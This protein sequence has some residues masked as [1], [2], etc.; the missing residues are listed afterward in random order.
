M[1]YAL[2]LTEFY[3]SEN[4]IEAEG[5]RN[6]LSAVKKCEIVGFSSVI[7]DYRLLRS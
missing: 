2:G 1:K 6:L 3:I 4:T 5:M 7:F